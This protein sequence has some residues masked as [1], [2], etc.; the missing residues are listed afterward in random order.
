MSVFQSEAITL[1]TYPYSESHK[2]VVFLTRSFG[3]VRGIAHGAKKSSRNRFGSSLEP[4]TQV[5]LTFSR[6]QNQELAVI[7]ESEIV[8]AFPA[9]QLSFEVNLHF[10]YFAELLQE[11]GNEEEESENLFRLALAVLGEIERA[12]IELLARYLELW[13]LKLEGVLPALD[14][15]LPKDLADKTEALLRL[16]PSKLDPLALSSGELKRL[17]RLGLSLLE[18]HLEKRLKTRAVL[19]ELLG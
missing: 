9:Y 3:L 7:Q 6:K 17:S 13:I 8:R 19:D 1:R 14:Q 4:L 11:V 18:S 2:I 10:S 12:P 5:L 15:R 16:H